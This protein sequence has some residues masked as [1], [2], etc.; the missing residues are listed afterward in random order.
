[1]SYN[2]SLAI[3]ASSLSLEE[4]LSWHITNFDQKPPKAMIG[5]WVAAITAYD[6]GLPEATSVDLPE[7][8][9]F[10]G[11]TKVS[12]AKIIED[13]HLEFYLASFKSYLP[14]SP[15]DA[16]LDNHLDPASR[17]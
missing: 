12:V 10:Q 11:G 3:A 5:I 7:G 17:N 4:K 15:L 9:T 1:M 14:A 2:L 13:F 6:L 8:S 16:P